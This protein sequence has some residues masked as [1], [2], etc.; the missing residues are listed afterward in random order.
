MRRGEERQSRLKR[1]VKKENKGW[2]W[3]E[4]EVKRKEWNVREWL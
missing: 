4:E 2:R 1:K 3:R